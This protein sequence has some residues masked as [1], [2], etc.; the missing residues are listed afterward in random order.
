MIDNMLIDKKKFL[1]RIKDRER[2]FQ[3]MSPARKRVAIAKDVIA[4]IEEKEITA[5]TGIYINDKDLWPTKTFFNSK[6]TVSVVRRNIDK[7]VRDIFV[8]E[9][10]PDCTACAVGSLFICAVKR[11]DKITIGQ[12]GSFRRSDLTRYLNKFFSKTQ[13][14]SIEVAFETP[15]GTKRNIAIF[16]DD[17]SRLFGSKFK[18]A[19]LRMVGI[20]KNIIA[21]DGEFIP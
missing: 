18:T 9:Y 21:N 1:K 14:N 17:K 11:Y 5:A 12:M 2:R 6:N 20:M 4:A 8:E 16:S 10:V 13:L 15:Y 3:K 19:K 7:Q